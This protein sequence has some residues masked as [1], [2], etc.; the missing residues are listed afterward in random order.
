MQYDPGHTRDFKDRDQ[1]DGL[2]IRGGLSLQTGS[3]SGEYRLESKCKSRPTLRQSATMPE[4]LP[5]FDYLARSCLS[6]K[7]IWGVSARLD[8]CAMRAARKPVDWRRIERRQTSA[9]SHP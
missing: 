3:Q 2:D 6:R 7:R 8:R 9:S 5:T 4:R 1:I